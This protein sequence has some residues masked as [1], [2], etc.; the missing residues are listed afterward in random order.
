MDILVYPFVANE[1]HDRVRE[2]RYAG[3]DHSM[4]YNHIFTHIANKCIT[5]TPTW[6]AY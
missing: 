2:Y 5:C 6:L 4:L 3:E 1:D